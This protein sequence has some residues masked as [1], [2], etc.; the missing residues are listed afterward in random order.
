ME[1]WTYEQ[2]SEHANRV[3]RELEVRGIAK[4]DAVLLWGENSAEWI[5]A[6]LGCLVRGVVVVPIDHAS[7]AE[8]A[9]RVSREVDA[10]LIF[11]A[12][13]HK[14]CGTVPSI[15][16]ESLFSATSHHDSSPY[17][18]PPTA[19][20][21]TLEIIFTSGTTAEPRGVMISHGNVLANI[22]P[23]QTEIQKYL[24]YETLFH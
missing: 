17:P 15:A 20:Q 14:D 16:L 2:I 22:K 6:F 7:T 19:R 1:S 23:L 13:A 4:G 5:A 9:C 24:R 18:P 12:G 3:A 11:R 10:K 8:F 21:D